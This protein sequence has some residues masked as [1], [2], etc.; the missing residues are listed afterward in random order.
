[1]RKFFRMLAA[2]ISLGGAAAQHDVDPGLDSSGACADGRWGRLF[3]ALDDVYRT[4]EYWQSFDS[5]VL[6]LTGTGGL[7]WY[8]DNYQGCVEGLLSLILYMSLHTANSKD[9]VTL[10]E[11]VARELNPLALRAGI[12]KWPFF[13]R[14]QDLNLLWQGGE[15]LAPLSTDPW[16]KPPCNERAPSM[17]SP[18]LF[19]LRAG[20]SASG[21]PDA[22]PSVFHLAQG[23][24]QGSILI[25]AGAFDGSDWAMEGVLAGATVLSFEPLLKNRRLFEQ[26]FPEALATAFMERCGLSAEEARLSQHR[27]TMLPVR[28]GERVP[29]PPFG[30]VFP[31]VSASSTC[32]ASGDRPLGYAYLVGA[33]LGER[34]RALNMTTRYDYSSIADQAY[35]KGPKDMEQE[36]VSMVTLDTVLAD[37]VAKASQPLPFSGIELLKVDVEGY[38]MGVLRGAERLLAEGRVHY[39]VIEFHPGMLGTTGTDPEGL[40]QF[41]QHYCFLCHSLKIA[42][43]YT[44]PAFVAR[45]LSSSKTL[46]IQG[47]GAL[48]DLVCQNLWWQPPPPLTQA[49]DFGETPPS[50]SMEL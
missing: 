10:A 40:L 13:G 21:N 23:L 47:L 8:K 42:R 16:H 18:L 5:T 33:A 17:V 32:V 45:Y 24:P 27:Y 19:T 29:R 28:P 36:E 37:Y 12:S 49:P 4:T 31:P 1:M 34:P 38:E 46:P 48:E 26:R 6:E 41:L 15:Q 25:D 35:L 43:P 50:D 20:A 2:L 44:F 11:R 39:L 7:D 22:S 30:D 3:V 14:L 9:F